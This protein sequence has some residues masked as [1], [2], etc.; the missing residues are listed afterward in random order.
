MNFRGNILLPCHGVENLFAFLLRIVSLRRVF[1]FLLSTSFRS[2]SFEPRYSR[3][4]LAFG[5][6]E[7]EYVYL[8]M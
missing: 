1:F 6:R 2:H 7:V 8:G 4:I 3:Y 5:V